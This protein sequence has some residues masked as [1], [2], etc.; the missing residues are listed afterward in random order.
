MEQ[1]SKKEIPATLK[2]I[3]AEINRT[4]CGIQRSTMRVGQLLDAAKGFFEKGAEWIEWA[5][6]EFGIG[7]VQVYRLVKVYETFGKDARFEGVAMR[8]LYALA[9]QDDPRIIVDAA[10]AA[11]KGE[12]DTNWIKEK[13]SPKKAESAPKAPANPENSEGPNDPENDEKGAG[14]PEIKPAAP[15]VLPSLTKPTTAPEAATPVNPEGAQAGAN[16]GAAVSESL[17]ALVSEVKELRA[18]IV[19][20]DAEIAGLKAAPKETGKQ[21]LPTLPHLFSK[22]PGIVL[23][24]DGETTDAEINARVRELIVLFKGNEEAV[25]LIQRARMALKD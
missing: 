12:L 24:L 16:A 10:E 7:K 15:V 8:V 20:K 17:A 22:N 23:G 19:A 21:A 1:I 4:L 5:N 18:L 6:N 14:E 2:G 25:G 11:E 9:T 13:T 3:A